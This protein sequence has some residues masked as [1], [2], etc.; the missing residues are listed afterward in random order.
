MRSG[1]NSKGFENA[2]GWWLVVWQNISTASG[3]PGRLVRSPTMRI[4]R[5][6]FGGRGDVLDQ[7]IPA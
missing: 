7:F 2:Q 5:L 1:L 4:T 3:R 6:G